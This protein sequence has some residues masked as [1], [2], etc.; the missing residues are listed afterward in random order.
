[1]WTVTSLACKNV[2]KWNE[3]LRWTLDQEICILKICG[4]HTHTHTHT[5]T[6]EGTAR[7]LSN[8]LMCFSLRSLT[9]TWKAAPILLLISTRCSAMLSL[10][11]E[12]HFFSCCLPDLTH[13]GTSASRTL[14]PSTCGR[15]RTKWV[16]RRH[17]SWVGSFIPK[18]FQ[19]AKAVGYWMSELVSECQHP[20][21][22]LPKCQLPKCQLPKC[23]LPKCQLPKCQLPKMSTPKMP[24]PKMSTF[25]FLFRISSVIFTGTH[26]ATYN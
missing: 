21:C 19:V 14:H 20:K 3:G 11:W 8:M 15:R 18:V 6:P 25:K 17:G 1:M 4:S 24:T 23:Q 26:I 16:G 5:V 7:Y 10:S 13:Y 12:W 22:Q 2:Y 9:F